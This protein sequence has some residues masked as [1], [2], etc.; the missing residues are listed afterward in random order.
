MEKRDKQMRIADGAIVF[1]LCLLQMGL[2]GS[3]LLPAIGC[4]AI[5]IC[6]TLTIALTVFAARFTR[7]RSSAYLKFDR[8]KVGAICGSALLYAAAI[9]AV[10]PVILFGHLLVPNFAASSF[11]ILDYK[12][13]GWWMILLI[14]LLASA[15]ETILFEGYLFSRFRYLERPMVRILLISLLFAVYHIE[16]YLLI[17]LILVECAILM[18]RER[19]DS[20]LIPAAL[21]YVTGLLS[22]SLLQASSSAERLLGSEMGGGQVTG[23]A[24]IFL[25]AAI[26]VWLL[27]GLLLGG[28]RKAT[29]IFTVILL[30][31]A[32]VLVAV[33]CGI[34]GT[35]F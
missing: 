33:G 13:S 16:L 20:M 4:W 31:A 17:P 32:L 28:K 23:L 2:L 35:E 21:H 34:S 27:G 11:H 25:G 3:F 14:P 9:L 19:T 10:I 5:L 7:L 12:A 26:P 18:I 6:E 24:L 15:A 29:P 22:I 1:M 30:S 8:P